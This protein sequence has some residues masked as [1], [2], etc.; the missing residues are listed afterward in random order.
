MKAYKIAPNRYFEFS[1]CKKVPTEL[2]DG[3]SYLFASLDEFDEWCGYIQLKSPQRISFFTSW[4]SAEISPISYRQVNDLLRVIDTKPRQQITLGKQTKPGRSKEASTLIPLILHNAHNDISGAYNKDLQT[5]YSCGY[6]IQESEIIDDFTHEFFLDIK[7]DLLDG[8]MTRV[9][10]NV[11]AVN[12]D[13]K[14]CHFI[15]NVE[16]RLDLSKDYVTKPCSFNAVQNF[17]GH[18]IDHMLSIDKLR[19]ILKFNKNEITMLSVPLPL[20]VENVPLFMNSRFVVRITFNKKTDDVSLRTRVFYLGS[21]E[22]NTLMKIKDIRFLAIGSLQMNSAKVDKN[23]Q[24]TL[25]MSD[26]Q[27]FSAPVTDLFITVVPKN[28]ADSN[29]LKKLEFFLNEKLHF[30]NDILMCNKII[31]KEL[32]GKNIPENMYIIPFVENPSNLLKGTINMSR[33]SKPQLTF[34][35]A[36]SGEYDIFVSWRYHSWLRL[37]DGEAVV[38]FLINSEQEQDWKKN[39]QKRQNSISPSVNGAVES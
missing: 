3:V 11:D 5:S 26:T 16:V 7:A 27:Y 24:I 33:V 15:K 6:R 30:S 1:H 12:S 32:Y 4:L 37:Q 35:F 2:L 13:F 28:P 19:N 18:A 23:N 25:D 8:M 38:R 34:T 29:T 36:I 10:F 21:S 22:R 14:V 17:S 20:F 39:K 31:P 9:E